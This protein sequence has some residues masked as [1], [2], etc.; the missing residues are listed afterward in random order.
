M[1]ITET[2]RLILRHFHIVDVEAMMQVFGDE[3]VM[4]YGPGVQT[5]EW[6]AKWVRGCLEDYHAKWGFGL[7]AVVAKRSRDVMGFCGLSRF[8]DVG[9]QAETEVGY[10]LGRAHWGK[11]FATEAA[12]AVRDYAFDS[13]GLNRLISIIDPQNRRSIRVATKLGMQYEKDVMFADYD[14]PDQ[15]YSMV[16]PTRESSS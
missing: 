10:R 15:V 2:D 11:G 6:V 8:P 4:R 3:E 5:R 13:L 9:G 12:L 16:H 7:W 14:H 1:L